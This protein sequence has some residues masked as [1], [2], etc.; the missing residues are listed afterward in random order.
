MP[1]STRGNNPS[2]WAL[3]NRCTSSTNS[4]VRAP[5][6]RRLPARSNTLRRSATPSNTAE[7]GSN[8]MPASAASRRAMVVFPVP[9]GPQKM[10]EASS[11]PSSIRRSRPCGP[12]SASWPT[13][14]DRSFGRSSSA[15]GA[16]ASASAPRRASGVSRSSWVMALSWPEAMVCGKE[17]GPPRQGDG[18]QFSIIQGDQAA[19]SSVCRSSST[20]T[21]PESW[22]RASSSRSTSSITA[23]GA[24]SP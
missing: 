13:T 2:C 9:G 18:P 16:L 14:S 6:S 24:E 21:G 10:I 20:C 12:R 7:I 5:A 4:S 11:P 1:S 17:K 22:P 19:V 23:I 3:L 15:S 8:S